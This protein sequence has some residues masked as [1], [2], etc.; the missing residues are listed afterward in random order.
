[1][2]WRT[3]TETATHAFI[4]EWETGDLA[5]RMAALFRES[6]TQQQYHKYIPIFNAVDVT[7]LLSLVEV[8]TLVLHPRQLELLGVDVARGLAARIP[9][10]RLT[11]LEGGGIVI[12]CDRASR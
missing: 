2:D 8:P 7:D 4:A 5:H 11:L 10:A 3:F 12:R 6:T 1:M 9:N